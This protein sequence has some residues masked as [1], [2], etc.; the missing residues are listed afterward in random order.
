M[1]EEGFVL[2]VQNALAA[3]TPPV[4]PP[5]GFMAEL[6]RDVISAAQKQA[7]TYRSIV[8]D[9]EYNLRGPGVCEWQVQIDCHGYAPD[10]AVSLARAVQKALDPGFTGTFADPDSTFVVGLFRL[11]HQVDLFSDANRT[12]VRAL[13]YAV[14]FH[15][16]T[17]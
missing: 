8:A 7:W 15:P 2:F 17:V 12:Y 6:P 5:G 10:D 3:L 14:Q 16:I 1:V 13:E 4:T 11:P 9:P